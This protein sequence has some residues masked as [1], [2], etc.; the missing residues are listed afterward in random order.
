MPIKKSQDHLPIGEELLT[1]PPS[2][3]EFMPK[4]IGQW[5]SHQDLSERAR[6]VPDTRWRASWYGF[7]CDLALRMRVDGVEPS[8]PADVSGLWRMGLGTMIHDALQTYVTEAFPEAEVEVAT[9]LRPELDGSATVDFLIDLTERVENGI[10]TERILLE[11][12]TLGGFGFKMAAAPFKGGPEGPKHGHIQQASIAAR[13][14]DCDRLIIG[15]VSMENIS[16]D[17]AASM[18]VDEIGKFTAEWH[19]DRNEIAIF[20]Q[21]AQD[22]ANLI[23][24]EADTGSITEPRFHDWNVPKQAVITEK[25]KWAVIEGNRRIKV[26]RAWCCSYCDFKDVCPIP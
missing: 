8:N 4:I 20:A 17:L 19:F 14:L 2:P 11:L 16:A 10:A 3:P 18:E 25:G 12:K 13:K 22:R 5:L 1:F 23:L 9:D 26:G 15:Y 24:T 7:P 21:E 6:A